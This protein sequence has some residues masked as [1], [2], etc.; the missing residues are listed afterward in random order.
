MS[1]NP[2][3]RNRRPTK[4][5]THLHHRLTDRDRQVI[6]LVALHGAVSRKQFM[7]FGLFRSVSRANRRLKQLLDAR[8]LR[9]K[10]LA[11][12]AHTLETIYL[13]GP[14]G[15]AIAAE[16]AVIDRVELARHAARHPERAYLEHQLGVVA[17]RLVLNAE[18]TLVARFLSETECRHEYA[19]VTGSK[20]VR[21]I[22]KPDA[23][24]EVDDGGVVRSFFLEFDRGHCSLPQMRGVFK[25][26]GLYASEGAF[27]E[28][29]GVATFEVLVVTTAGARRITH[30]I[31]AARE[32]GASV[33]FA[34]YHD[35]CSKG[36]FSATWQDSGSALPRLVDRL[37]GRSP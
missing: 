36:F 30:L 34:T 33:R 6:T 22:I 12:S 9:R 24:F 14:T 32:S 11:I 5:G 28:A 35:V 20:S 25:R 31:E 15:V 19:L 21:R 8:Y 13:L 1:A 10:H 18:Q 7:Q 27:Q 2:H 16:L 3:A 29:Y 17:L 4:P 26:Y 37:E 23:Y